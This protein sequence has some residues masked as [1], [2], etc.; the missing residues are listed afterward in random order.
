MLAVTRKE[1]NVVRSGK[2]TNM[3]NMWS[4]IPSS[5]CRETFRKVRSMDKRSANLVNAKNLL[6]EC[7]SPFACRHIHELQTEDDHHQ[8]NK[9]KTFLLHSHK[10]TFLQLGFRLTISDFTMKKSKLGLK[11]PQTCENPMLGR[12]FISLTA[13]LKKFAR[14]SAVFPQI[15]ISRCF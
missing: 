2:Q 12:Y 3:N 11:P 4:T 5:T 9:C 7:F 13:L 6:Q 10:P 8:L 14:K 1:K 15:T